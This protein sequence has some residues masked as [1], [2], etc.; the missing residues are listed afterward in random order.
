ME[1]TPAIQ[2]RRSFAAWSDVV[3]NRLFCYVYRL[4][5][6]NRYGLAWFLRAIYD[7]ILAHLVAKS[8]FVAAAN[9]M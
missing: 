5:G 2:S 9:I 1:R 7:D 3:E 6:G 8:R 4:A